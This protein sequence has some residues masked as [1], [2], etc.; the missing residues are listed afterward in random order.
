MGPPGVVTFLAHGSQSDRQGGVGGDS[1]GKDC[2][3]QRP[4]HHAKHLIND[5]I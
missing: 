3:F 4:W 2:L 1:Q 5:T